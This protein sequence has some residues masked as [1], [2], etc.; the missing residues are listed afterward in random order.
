MV[1]AAV[2]AA[3]VTRNLWTWLLPVFRAL[4]GSSGKEI[5]WLALASFFPVQFWVGAAL[6]YLYSRLFP[7]KWAAFVCIPPSLWFLL[8]W[9]TFHPGGESLLSGT[10][11]GAKWEHF[12]SYA[13]LPPRCY[14]QLI[15][16]LPM[17]S[18]IGYT[19]GI[20]FQRVGVFTFS[21]PDPNGPS[22]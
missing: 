13:C 12:F 3:F 5:Y 7:E 10:P 11:F 22:E 20:V 16:V 8:R 4:P 21:S 1:V 14:D 15:F 19:V 2:G 6:G 17:I 18:A 9:I